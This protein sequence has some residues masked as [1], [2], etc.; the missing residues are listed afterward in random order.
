MEKINFNTIHRDLEFLK[1]AVSKII[2]SLSDFDVLL[3]DND[4]ESI[5]EY[6]KEKFENK[7]LSHKEVL[8]AISL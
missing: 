3:D 4:M 7:L 8:N 5:Q 2:V 6:E 1:K